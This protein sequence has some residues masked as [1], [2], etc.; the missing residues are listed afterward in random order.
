MDVGKSE[1][2]RKEF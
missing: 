1:E 2:S